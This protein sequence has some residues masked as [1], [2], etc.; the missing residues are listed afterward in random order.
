MGDV[1]DDEPLVANTT[2]GLGEHTPDAD[3][4]ELYRF[5]G[6]PLSDSELDQL[7]AKAWHR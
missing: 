1:T 4:H 6:P 2:D 7:T 5:G 3:D